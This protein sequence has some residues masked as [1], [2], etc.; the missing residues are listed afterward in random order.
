MS[1]LFIFLQ[2]FSS[3]PNFPSTKTDYSYNLVF[4]PNTTE[5]V[6]IWYYGFE[7]RENIIYNSGVRQINCCVVKTDMYFPMQGTYIQRVMWTKNRKVYTWRN[8]YTVRNEL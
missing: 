1:F 6:V 3:L 2:L 4:P 5:I 7:R 8:K